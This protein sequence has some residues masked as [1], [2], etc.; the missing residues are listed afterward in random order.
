[1]TKNLY[2]YVFVF[3]GLVFLTV[4]ITN[5]I[6]SMINQRNF[7]L[8]AHK[9]VF[10]NLM[11]TSYPATFT[12]YQNSVIIS[13]DSYVQGSGDMFL[14]G[15]YNYSI[16]HLLHKDLQLN[17]INMGRGGASNVTAVHNIDQ[18]RKLHGLSLFHK[19]MPAPNRIILFFYEGNDLYDNLR[20]LERINDNDEEAK[21]AT[22][23]Y[24]IM[25]S[26]LRFS[27]Y[28][29]ASFFGFEF[30]MRMSLHLFREI[31]KKPQGSESISRNNDRY[32]KVIVDGV[33]RE[34][35]VSN[36]QA[37]AVELSELELEASL[38]VLEGSLEYLCLEYPSDQLTVVYIPSAAS[39]YQWVGDI[40]I[41]ST[42][43]RAN[44]IDKEGNTTRSNLIR[45]RVEELTKRFSIG[46]V[47]TSD[48]LIFEGQTRLLHGP[49][50]WKHFNRDGHLV[51]MKSLAPI[52]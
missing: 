24:L 9:P 49:Q 15:E 6:V 40:N 11:E 34:A 5:S 39:I 52:L 21:Q 51:L 45:K 22:L 43:Q 13:G 36:I 23:S 37:A 20:F 30:M 17:V 27:D 19:E 26:K 7:P 25:N 38:S 48:D 50:D 12:S 46:F 32:N 28:V 29:Q 47:D 2:K 3:G 44:R 33:S 41:Q 4:L 16:G 35:R 31:T 14:S 8:L 10:P 1:M 42:L 18:V